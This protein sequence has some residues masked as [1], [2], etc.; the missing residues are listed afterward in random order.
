MPITI[1][2]Q[3]IHKILTEFGLA[4]QISKIASAQSG[5][6]NTVIPMYF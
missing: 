5:Y 3:L 4:Q 2:K 1:S 6:R